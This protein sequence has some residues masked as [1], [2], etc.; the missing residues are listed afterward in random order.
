[1]PENHKIQKKLGFILCLTVTYMIIEAVGGIMTNSLALI[2]DAGHMMGDV[3]A[4]TMSF[5]A[6]V[7]VLKP[8]S[9]EKTF[10]Y[11]RMEI[12]VALINGLLLLGIAVFILKEG[13]HR[14]YTP[15]EVQAP[16][17]IAIATGG[18]VINLIGMLVLRSSSKHNLTV[19]GAFLHIM[20]DTLGSLGAITAGIIIYVYKFYYADVITSLLIA[21]LITISA[22]RLIKEASNILLE[23]TPKHVDTNAIKTAILEIK[24]VKKVH[25]LHVWCI[26]LQRIAL[27]I[28]V[29]SDHPDSKEILLQVDSL[30][31]ERFNINHLTIQVEPSGFPE[32]R[33]DF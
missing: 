32:Q 22:I 6:T 1:M 3:A 11:Y 16:L 26:S 31:R 15:R 28:H 33:C 25:E 29:V 18:L 13:I 4:L 27:S 14:L 24:D 2:A 5:W 19:K 10:G 30:L 21:T 12:L 8:A 20:G 9:P 7:M 17:M 23:G